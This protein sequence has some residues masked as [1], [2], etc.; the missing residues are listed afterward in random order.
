M[1][2]LPIHTEKSVFFP[3][4]SGRENFPGG[5]K[6]V[7]YLAKLFFPSFVGKRALQK[8]SNPR[9]NSTPFTTAS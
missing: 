4:I 6:N 9:A 3:E 1:G 7:R 5:N 2:R 8:R